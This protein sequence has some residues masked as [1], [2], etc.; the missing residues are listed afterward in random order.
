[1]AKALIRV[2]CLI[3]TISL[4][5]SGCAATKRNQCQKIIELAND[6]VKEAR[7]LTNGQKSTDPE[8]ALL[9]A[10]TME[11]AAQEMASLEISDPKLQ[12]YQK[13]FIDMYRNTAQATRSFVKAYEKTDQ[14][15]LK[16]AR[17][18]LKKATAPEEELVTKINQYCLE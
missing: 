18:Q 13:D 16:Q 5:S 3:V 7:N 9:A 6:T 17:E 12:Q 8:A 11:M 2:V 1:M 15:Q 4:I 14:R 10:D